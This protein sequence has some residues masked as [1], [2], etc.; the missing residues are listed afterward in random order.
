M[1][2]KPSLSI[3]DYITIRLQTGEEIVGPVTDITNEYIE[4]A[5]PRMLIIQQGQ[6]GPVAGLSVFMHLADP[7]QNFPFYKST[8]ITHAKL[9]E[10]SKADYIQ[11]VSGII[12][13]SASSLQV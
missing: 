1:L 12:M 6:N 13:P 8:I 9:S 2:K 5:K 10:N 4:L 11:A 3:G 7:D